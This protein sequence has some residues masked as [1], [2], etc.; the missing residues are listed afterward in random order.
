[1]QLTHLARKGSQ[2]LRIK[3]D[4]EAAVLSCSGDPG[5]GEVQSSRRSTSRLTSRLKLLIANSRDHFAARSLI[6]GYMFDAWS[7]RQCADQFL[8]LNAPWI[9]TVEDYLDMTLELGLRDYTLPCL[10]TVSRLEKLRLLSLL[11]KSQRLSSKGLQELALWSI[12]EAWSA[13]LKITEPIQRSLKQSQQRSPLD[14]WI[15]ILEEEEHVR[16]AFLKVFRSVMCR[17]LVRISGTDYGGTKSQVTGSSVDS[18]RKRATEELASWMSRVVAILLEDGKTRAEMDREHSALLSSWDTMVAARSSSASGSSINLETNPRSRKRPLE[19]SS[20]LSSLDKILTDDSVYSKSN[21]SLR[22]RHLEKS[23]N[24]YPNVGLDS[25]CKSFIRI[26]DSILLHQETAEMPPKKLSRV[27][28]EQG[29]AKNASL[30][31]GRLESCRRW[32]ESTIASREGPWRS[33]VKLKL[34]FYAVFEEESIH[35]EFADLINDCGLHWEL[36]ATLQRYLKRHVA[37]NSSLPLNVLQLGCELLLSVYAKK[38]LLWNHL[39]DHLYAISRSLYFDVSGPLFGSWD[40][41]RLDIDTQLVATLNQLVALKKSSSDFAIPSHVKESLIKI[42]LIAPY[43]VLHKIVEAASMNRGQCPVLLRTLLDLGQLSWLRATTAEPALLAAVIQDIICEVKGKSTWTPHQLDNF[44][45][46][47]FGAVTQLSSS[48]QPLLD[49]I[50]FLVECVVPLLKMMRQ[51][52]ESDF[53]KPVAV[54]LTKTYETTASEPLQSQQWLQNEVQATVLL[55]LLDLCNQQ[56]PNV[57]GDSL[58]GVQIRVGSSQFED[59]SRLCSLMVSI[60]ADQ[61]HSSSTAFVNHQVRALWSTI[62]VLQ[63]S[64][65]NVY[66][67]SQLVALPLLR[68]CGLRISNVEWKPDLDRRISILCGDKMQVCRISPLRVISKTGSRSTEQS[69]ILAQAILLFLHYSSLCDIVAEDLIQAVKS[70]SMEMKPQSQNLL[71]LFLIPALYRI[72]STC[73]SHES[74]RILVRVVPALMECWGGIGA[75]DWRMLFDIEPSFK[76]KLGSYWD[77]ARISME[78]SPEGEE[79]RRVT[80]SVISTSESLLRLAMDPYPR[81]PRDAIMNVYGLDVGYDMFVDQVASLI[82][83]AVKSLQQDWSQVSLDYLLYCFL[84]ACNLCQVCADSRDP[85]LP[86][87]VYVNSRPIH[88]QGESSDERILSVLQEADVKGATLPTTEL[89]ESRVR[90]CAELLLMAMNIS[91]EIVA[92]QD[93]FYKDYEPL[94]ENTKVKR[95]KFKNRQRS[96]RNKNKARTKSPLVDLADEGSGLATDS[97][98]DRLM[99]DTEG[100][101]GATKA[102]QSTVMGLGSKP[103]VA[104]DLESPN[105]SELSIGNSAAETETPAQTDFDETQPPR[106]LLNADQVNCLR[107]AVSLLP[108]QESQAVQRRL[109]RLLQEDKVGE[110][111]PV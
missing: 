107:L 15:D 7:S 54:V 13:S 83:T 43:Q 92:R 22:P 66:S 72:L 104:Q 93:A 85:T 94:Q 52:K 9:L 110:T 53:F 88:F 89:A 75:E 109:V 103:A 8:S 19:T 6:H 77:E 11:V 62:S 96:S 57:L 99:D 111:K 71:K 4:I 98:P 58:P 106:G 2:A 3:I 74:Q 16:Y 33:C 73:S 60:L 47:L 59:L 29:S 55:Y 78:G 48:R 63:D 41:W 23:E 56:R 79:G 44:A 10:S 12:D 65:V 1:M 49:R 31:A 45:E 40:F 39:R 64:S 34:Q 61:V 5:N 101:D 81:K 28:L 24:T 26:C 70:T 35:E 76:D 69:L 90:A 84:L 20:S 50:E 51:R 18:G 32:V 27:V 95:G 91:E 105:R 80:F 97:I 102:W 36:C 30:E 42:S 14:L 100:M 25:H 108:Q 37:S 17:A 82:P 86:S 21:K 67:T 46:F 87:R 38:E 68:A